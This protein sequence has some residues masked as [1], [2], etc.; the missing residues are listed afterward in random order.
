[1]QKLQINI[2]CHKLSAVFRD[3]LMDVTSVKTIQRV[4]YYSPTLSP[5]VWISA[6]SSLYPEWGAGEI[7]RP[8]LILLRAISSVLM[9]KVERCWILKT[10]YIQVTFAIGLFL[11]PAL[12]CHKL[13]STPL[14]L[15]PPKKH[16]LTHIKEILNFFKTLL[17]WLYFISYQIKYTHAYTWNM[18]V[19]YLL[20]NLILQL[21]QCW[22]LSSDL[23]ETFLWSLQK[24]L[25]AYSLIFFVNRLL[26]RNWKVAVQN[27]L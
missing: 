3:N 11:R 2:V 4:T 7:A 5:V 13:E 9:H 21:S 23:L 25:H 22:K 26:A 17:T 6:V 15:P 12:S 14:P 18:A 24:F 19:H 8:A 10:C 20:Y 1:M 27:M 16:A